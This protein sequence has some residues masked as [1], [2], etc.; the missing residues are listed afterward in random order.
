[1]NAK[2]NALH[3]RFR[4]L[5][6]ILGY[7]APFLHSPPQCGHCP[8]R[9]TSMTSSTLRG[10]GRRHRRPYWLPALR[11]GFCGCALDPAER[12]GRLTLGRSHA[13]SNKRRSRSFSFFSSSI[14]RSRWPIFSEVSCPHARLT[15]LRTKTNNILGKYLYAKQLPVPCQG[16]ALITSY[17]TLT[18][19]GISLPLS[20]GGLPSAVCGSLPTECWL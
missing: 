1:M 3:S 20:T 11:P 8:G 15:T 19:H 7:D 4:N 10:T 2:L 17:S 13:S 5:G 14:S 18:S 12:R 9:G 6:L 16:P